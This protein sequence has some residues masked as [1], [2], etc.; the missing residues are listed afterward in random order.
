MKAVSQILSQYKTDKN[1][2]RK[3]AH[4]YGLAY[5]QLLKPFDRFAQLD[6]IEIGTEYGESLLAWKEY[7]PNANI[8]GIDIE[9]KVANRNQYIEY[10]ISDIKN[11]KPDKEF[12][13]VIDDG[14]HKLSDV[15][16]TVKNFK[17]KVGGIMVI[18][19]C[20]APVHWYEAIKNNTKY[21]IE[22]IDLRDI[23]SQRDDFLIVLRNYGYISI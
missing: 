22:S 21:S 9:D 12:D 7:F 1:L 2:C 10:I 4:C 11:F 19:D 6:I 8:T 16:Y 20:Q 15:L 14:S 3:G 17:L 13:I 23:Y 5:D 18:E